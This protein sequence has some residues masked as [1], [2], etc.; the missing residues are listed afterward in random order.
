MAG[1][2]KGVGAEPG[3]KLI[4]E[5]RRARHDYTVDEKLEAGLSLLGSE[6]KALRE[7]TANLADAYAL[8]KGG[9]LFLLNAHIGVY[10]PASVFTHE[11]TRG[12]KLLLHRAELDRWA[13]KVRERGY[14]IIPLV[15]YFRDGKAKVE[16][17]LCRGKTH[18]D[19]RQDIKERET[20]R[21]MDRA[22]RRR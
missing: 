2:P 16:L 11:P 1:K 17:G 18:E 20:K 10:N 3:V 13:A 5:N 19:R 4:A 21:E 6:V 7:G 8:P 15:L 12:R 9:E 14:S 22:V